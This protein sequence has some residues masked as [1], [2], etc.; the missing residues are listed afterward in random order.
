MSMVADV[1][2][3]ITKKGGATVDELVP[4]M[5]CTRLQAKD[6]LKN[7]AKRNLIHIKGWKSRSGKGDGAGRLPPTYYPGPKPSDYAQ[8]MQQ[9]ERVIRCRPPAS[10]WEL[11]HGLQIAG[12]W[13]LPFEG[14]RVFVSPEEAEEAA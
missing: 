4:E 13:P 10:V 7:A 11:A 14:G 5:G 6:A 9:P 2:R 1:C 12:D 8:L 3:L